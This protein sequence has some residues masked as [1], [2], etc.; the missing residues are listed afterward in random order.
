MVRKEFDVTRDS[1]QERKKDK[2]ENGRSLFTSPA[3]TTNIVYSPRLKGLTCCLYL[4]PFLFDSI[5][6]SDRVRVLKRITGAVGA[7]G[8]GC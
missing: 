3:A 4:Q 6:I 7:S 8:L 2:T 5:C 1:K